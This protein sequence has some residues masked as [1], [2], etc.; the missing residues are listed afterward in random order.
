MSWYRYDASR[1]RLTLRLHIQPGAKK[2]QIV[3]LH[4]D[5][6]KIKVA[7]AP[8]E[9]AANEALRKFLA[10]LFGVPS[11]QVSITSGETSRSKILEVLNPVRPVDSVLGS[12]SK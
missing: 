8:V 3:G 9:G 10:V 1:T 2:T 11:R 4:G 7:A 6:L 12:I 5:A